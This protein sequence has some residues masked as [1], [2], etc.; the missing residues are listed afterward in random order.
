MPHRNLGWTAR[1]T[2]Q[3]SS[4]GLYKGIF[5]YKEELLARPFPIFQ[6]PKIHPVFHETLAQTIFVKCAW[7]YADL[8]RTFKTI[9]YGD[10]GGKQIELWE[11][12]YR[13]MGQRKKDSNPCPPR[14]RLGALTTELQRDY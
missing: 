10:F 9:V 2:G 7:E 4:S 1:R 13:R 11:I 8:P 6:F 14:C 5:T 3:T 12:S